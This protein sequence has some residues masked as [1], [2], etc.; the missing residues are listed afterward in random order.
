MNN[1]EGRGGGGVKIFWHDS[2]EEPGTGS[3]E[4]HIKRQTYQLVSQIIKFKLKHAR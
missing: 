3:N 4:S 1:D 2:K